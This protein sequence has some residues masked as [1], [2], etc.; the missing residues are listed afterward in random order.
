MIGGIKGTREFRNL[1]ERKNTRTTLSQKLLKKIGYE[2]KGANVE[3]KRSI[4][5][6]L[7]DETRICESSK[8]FIALTLCFRI[9]SGVE[10]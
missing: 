10:K 4:E 1:R 3:T 8:L 7:K 6:R 2:F 9:R 5:G